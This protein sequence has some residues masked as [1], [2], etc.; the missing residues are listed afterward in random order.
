M[1]LMRLYWHV[2]TGDRREARLRHPLVKR[3]P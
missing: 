2:R 3:T 1:F